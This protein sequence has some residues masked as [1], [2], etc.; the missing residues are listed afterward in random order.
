MTSL[1][2]QD[3][4]INLTVVDGSTYV[5]LYAQDGSWNVV[6]QTANTSNYTGRM[7]A[8]GA[9]NVILDSGSDYLGMN[10]PNGSLYVNQ[11][12]RVNGSQLVT[13]V[14]GTLGGGGPSHRA[15]VLLQDGSYLLLQSSDT[16]LLQ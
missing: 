6:D 14:S 2:A 1:Y 3:G 4:S 9:I 15:S 10:A 13:V 16:I 11:T 8:C 7:H 5:G 12:T